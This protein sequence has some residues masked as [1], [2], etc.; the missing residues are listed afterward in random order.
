MVLT[1]PFGMAAGGII[2]GA[3]LSA[4]VGTIQQAVSKEDKFNHKSVLIQ[5][6][7][8]AL[9]GAIAAP[10]AAGGGALAAVVTN[11]AGKISIQ[12]ASAS[13]GGALSGAGS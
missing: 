7:V 12:V 4:E 2:L 6:G 8:G 5:A 3:G 13:V 10:I 1:G 11:T 9:G